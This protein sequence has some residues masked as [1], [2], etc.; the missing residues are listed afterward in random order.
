MYKAHE[1]VIVKK[2]GRFRWAVT[3]ENIILT[4][5]FKKSMADFMADWLNGVIEGEFGY[6]EVIR[7]L[8]EK[9]NAS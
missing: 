8:S 2:Y 3:V 9:A 6:R 5:Y 4:W 1:L 7:T